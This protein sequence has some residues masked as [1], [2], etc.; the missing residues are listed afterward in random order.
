MRNMFSKKN[1]EWYYVQCME[2]MLASGCISS[3][4]VQHVASAASKPAEVLRTNGVNL[5]G[6]FDTLNLL[7]SESLR[8]GRILQHNFC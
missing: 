5:Q 1:V 4:S 8:N 7:P 6:K 2:S 3:V